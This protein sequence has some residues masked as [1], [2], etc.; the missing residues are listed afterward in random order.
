MSTKMQ[1][2]A[3]SKPAV[4]QSRIV[5][6]ISSVIWGADKDI[7]DREKAEEALRES[8]KRYRMLFESAGDCVYILDA[9]GE[10][11][12]QIVSANPT[13]A[14]MH[15]YTVEEILSLNIA[16]LDSPESA[17]NCTGPDRAAFEGRNG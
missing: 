3:F 9:E 11:P 12:G 4:R 1:K 17:R 10:Q 6:E 2:Y 8:E 13:A 5:K 14:R 15:G 7:T 16:D